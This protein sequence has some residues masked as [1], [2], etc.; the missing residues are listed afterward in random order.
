MRVP[1]VDDI[2]DALRNTSLSRA[3]LSA[4]TG[5]HP[6]NLSQ[7]KSGKRELSL[8]SLETLAKALGMEIVLRKSTS[9]SKK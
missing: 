3:E 2:R 8:Q 9:T 6:V 7:F 5:I 4:T 1:I